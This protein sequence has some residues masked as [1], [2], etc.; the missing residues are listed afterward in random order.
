[1]PAAGLKR[2]TVH[3]Y[4][5]SGEVT[6]HRKVRKVRFGKRE[7]RSGERRRRRSHDARS[8]ALIRAQPGMS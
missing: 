6:A 8:A 2:I 1:M 5:R 7:S 3:E 4:K